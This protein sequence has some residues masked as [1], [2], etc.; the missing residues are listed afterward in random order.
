MP[1]VRLLLVLLALGGLPASALAQSGPGS[2]QIGSLQSL[3]QSIAKL[4]AELTE[5]RAELQAESSPDL[6]EEL[7]REIGELRARRALQEQT[8]QN[9]A[10]GIDSEQWEA[11]SEIPFSL[12]KEAEE[13]LKPFLSEVRAASSEAREAEAVRSEIR[14]LKGRLQLAQTAVSNLQQTV[15]QTPEADLQ[16]V[17]QELLGLWQSRVRE[18]DARLQAKEVELAEYQ[19][20]RRSFWETS[21]E[22]MDHFFRTRGQNVLFALL[23]IVLLIWGM[24]VLYRKVVLRFSPL[25]RRGRRNFYTR[26]F[27][28]SYNLGISVLSVLAAVITFYAAGDWLLLSLVILFLLG[29]AWALKHTL[30]RFFDQLRLILNLGPVREGERLVYEGVPWQVRKLNFYS[31]FVNP[32]LEGGLM[33]LPVGTVLDLHSRPIAENEAWFPTGEND[34]VVLQ[35]GLYGKIVQQTPE[36]VHLVKLGGSRITI[37]TGTF[38]EMTPEN[39]SHNFRLSTTFGIDYQH[40]RIATDRVAPL[41]QSHLESQ[42]QAAVGADHL[43]NLQVEFK[44]AGASSLDY[45]VLADFSGKVADR[46]RRLERALARLCTEVCNQQGWI[47]PFTQLTLH[48]ATPLPPE[49]QTPAPPKA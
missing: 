47:I 2:E 9:V 3:Y 42:L 14:K 48:H 29:L 18:L 16:P 46:Y 40:Q 15:A 25:H 21:S 13:L 7:T 35:N 37:P 33:R 27:D 32:A 19:A 44:A 5:K 11:S 4:E 17:L 36:F 39:L 20:N 12:A 24:K 10:T 31:T 1:L 34:W 22:V 28:L 23:A 6:I 30:P 8:F 38:L 43:L 49:H 45:I 41:F 26:V